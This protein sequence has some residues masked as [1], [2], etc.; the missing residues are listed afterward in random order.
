[1]AGVD[2]LIDKDGKPWILEVNRGPG[3]TYD[4]PASPE[5]KNL[6]KFF[7]QELNNIHK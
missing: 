4:D 7:V 5:L 2:L 6:A 1:M 3:F